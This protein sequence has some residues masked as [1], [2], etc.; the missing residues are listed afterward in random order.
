[1]KDDVDAADGRAQRIGLGHIAQH[2]FGA[3]RP[4]RFA[5]CL[6]AD[7]GTHRLTMRQQGAR[8]MF[9]D[10]AIS[11]GNEGFHGRAAS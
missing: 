1:M 5:G 3:Q 8:Q 2:D 11:A 10:E 4:Q 7:H 6:A 9:A